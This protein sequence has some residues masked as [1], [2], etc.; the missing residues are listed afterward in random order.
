MGASQFRTHYPNPFVVLHGSVCRPAGRAHG[1]RVERSRNAFHR[2]WRN[3][4][5][6]PGSPWRQPRPV[7]QS[8]EQPE[9]DQ[10]QRRRCQCEFQRGRVVVIPT[11]STYGA[12]L[13]GK[14]GQPIPLSSLRWAA[15]Q[16]HRRHR[17]RGSRWCDVERLVCH[18]GRRERVPGV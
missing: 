15:G 7:D 10:R 12:V 16:Q 17:Q 6:R 3:V 4:Y 9:H 5:Q 1:L 11:Q 8:H 14:R 13:P 2:R 18:G